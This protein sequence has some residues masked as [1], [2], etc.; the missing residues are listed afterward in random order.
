MRVLVQGGR[1]D[2]ARRNGNVRPE[3]HGAVAHADRPR[4]NARRRGLSAALVAAVA[5]AA[6]A[7][8]TLRLAG[9]RRVSQG[10]YAALR[11]GRSAPSHWYE[12]WSE[13]RGRCGRLGRRRA[14][15]ESAETARAAGGRQRREH[16]SRG[17]S[18][19]RALCTLPQPDARRRRRE[20]RCMARGHPPRGGRQVAHAAAA[21]R[22][23]EMLCLAAEWWDY[24]AAGVRAA[25]AA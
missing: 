11:R 10:R 21:G 2:R 4:A 9:V 20:R 3:R 19:V 1:A 16:C 8:T 25:A 13:A 6:T 17:A 22:R 12:R 24:G 7:A 23:V 5:A 18:L 14:R 15:A